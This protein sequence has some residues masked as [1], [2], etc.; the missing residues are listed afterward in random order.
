[1]VEEEEAPPQEKPDRARPWD[2]GQD[3]IPPRPPRPARLSPFVF[4][5]LHSI[6]L[7]RPGVFISRNLTVKN[8]YYRYISTK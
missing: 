8:I 7:L 4:P 2:V 3:F 6:S 1:M 5:P